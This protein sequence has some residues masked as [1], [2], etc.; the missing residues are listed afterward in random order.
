MQVLDK[1]CEKMITTAFDRPREYKDWL[2]SFEKSSYRGEFGLIPDFLRAL[3]EPNQDENSN[4]ES[5]F[6][7]YEEI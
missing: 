2:D 1:L 4:I 6:S 7:V 5:D 3:T